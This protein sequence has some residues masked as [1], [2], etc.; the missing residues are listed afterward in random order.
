M[1]E[2]K[3]AKT[4]KNTA[5]PEDGE[6]RDWDPPFPPC[7]TILLLPLPSSVLA[8]PRGTAPRGGR[9]SRRR[10]TAD[11]EANSR[12]GPG[13]SLG[14]AIA[15]PSPSPSGDAHGPICRLRSAQRRPSRPSSSSSSSSSSPG[16][17]RQRGR[18]G[19][20]KKIKIKQ[21]GRKREEEGQGAPRQP[22]TRSPKLAST[23][24]LHPS[25]WAAAHG[26]TDRGPRP[27]FQSQIPSGFPSPIRFFA[28]PVCLPRLRLLLL[29][30]KP[31]QSPAVAPL[32]PQSRIQ[33][34]PPPAGPSSPARPMRLNPSPAR[35]SPQ[36]A[37]FLQ[38]M[39]ARAKLDDAL[40]DRP[41][42][43]LS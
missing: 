23:L 42:T 9:L 40:A 37:R 4:A 29:L 34:P 38:R 39:L 31:T 30:V 7:P 24:V 11:Q 2:E 27:F 28:S 22:P 16:G 12:P 17:G 19:R 6:S 3:Q 8:R 13:S 43:G 21:K 20:R 32:P 35:H 15:E 41:R 18:P 26:P 14:M 10:P 33:L 5:R 25:R 36:S 1:G